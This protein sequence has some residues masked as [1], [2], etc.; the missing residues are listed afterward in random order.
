ML[1]KSL[2]EKEYE[3]K[4]ISERMLLISRSSSSFHFSAREL[5][6]Q[7]TLFLS[8]LA[9]SLRLCHISKKVY[10][11]RRVRHLKFQRTLK[12]LGT[13]SPHSAPIHT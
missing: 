5:R 8:Y 3:E 1:Y 2:T 10:E 7:L 11:P 12:S 9:E 4:R 6:S 13:I